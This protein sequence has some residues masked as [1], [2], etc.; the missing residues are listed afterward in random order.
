M[1]R[2]TGILGDYGQDEK[3]TV[4]ETVERKFVHFW[5]E[6]REKSGLESAQDRGFGLPKKIPLESENQLARLKLLCRSANNPKKSL[7]PCECTT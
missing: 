2:K 3:R 5:G 1:A 6:M 7:F 4:C